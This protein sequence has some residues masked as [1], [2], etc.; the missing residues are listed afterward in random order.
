M[1]ELELEVIVKREC[2]SIRFGNRA[3]GLTHEDAD[4]LF[5]LFKEALEKR[6]AKKVEE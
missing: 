5:I 6:D 3:Y 4:R 2:V 1:S